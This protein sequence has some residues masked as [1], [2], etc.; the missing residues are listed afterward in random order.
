[1]NIAVSSVD[2]RTDTP[3]FSRIVEIER[4]RENMIYSISLVICI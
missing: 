4:D 2:R 3:L 1:M